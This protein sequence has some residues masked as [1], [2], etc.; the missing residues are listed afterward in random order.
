M[1]WLPSNTCI[2]N[3]APHCPGLAVPEETCDKAKDTG[4][5]EAKVIV[6]RI[7]KLIDF[8]LTAPTSFLVIYKWTYV[9]CRADR[10][11]V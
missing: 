5:K 6:T 9:E 7:K 2:S 11:P 10:D 8:Q 1:I 4:S 3:P